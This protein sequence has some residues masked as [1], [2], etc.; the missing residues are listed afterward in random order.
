MHVSHIASNLYS[1]RTD[2]RAATTAPSKGELQ[3][4]ELEAVATNG[5]DATIVF[6]AAAL[7]F[8]PVVFHDVALTVSKAT[9]RI[10][11]A[12]FTHLNRLPEAVDGIAVHSVSTAAALEPAEAIQGRLHH[13]EGRLKV[14]P[15]L[16][17][18]QLERGFAD[19]GD[20]AVRLKATTFLLAPI[21]LHD[22]WKS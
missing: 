7:A 17:A 10:D 14:G 3:T 8:A 18:A 9:R 1:P 19:G 20:P 13:R 21:L 22:V 5:P 6:E 4:A 16:D 11:T 12:A 15:D 2:R